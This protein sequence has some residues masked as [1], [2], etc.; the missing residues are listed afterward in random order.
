MDNTMHGIVYFTK[1]LKEDLSF[2]PLVYE[3]ILEG[4]YL[5]NPFGEIFSIL[6]NRIMSQ[7]TNHAGY[8]RV[9]LITS[10]G[11]R[12]FSVHRLVAA[13]FIVNPCPEIYTDVD[14]CNGIKSN[15]SYLN[16]SWCTNNQNKHKAS[17]MGLYQHGEERY[18]SVYSDNFARE[19]CDRFQNGESYESVYSY[20]QTIY[21]G[22][23][24]T[25]GSFIYKL[26]HRKTRDFITKNY[27]Y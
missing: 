15:N 19:I 14:H 4:R 18:N 9:C 10:N 12:N 3:D 24:S 13:T 23:G 27:S 1:N 11:P 26:Y 6:K 2:V 25:I 20:Y 16:L 5:I 22:T 21:P 8:K 17:V 7:D